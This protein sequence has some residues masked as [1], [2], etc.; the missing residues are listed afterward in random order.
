[1]LLVELPVVTCAS[2]ESRER[3]E[4]KQRSVKM[5]TEQ[6]FKFDFTPVSSTE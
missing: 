6:G 2:I 5:S 3:K 1:M 4:T